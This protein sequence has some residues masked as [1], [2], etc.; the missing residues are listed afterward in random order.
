MTGRREI[1]LALG[2]VSLVGTALYAERA[3]RWRAASAERDRLS[4]RRPAGV[5]VSGFDEKSTADEVTQGLDLSGKTILV[6]GVTSGIGLETMRV[7][8]LRGA[9]V[10]GTGR[11][12]DRAQAACASVGGRT[13]PLMLELTDYPSV[14]ACAERVRAIGAPLDVLVCNAGVM[15]LQ[16][17]EQVDG[18]ERHFATNHLGHFL[19]VCHLMDLVKGAPQG[20]VVVVS[21]NNLKG[22]NPK[23]IE[24][25]NLDGQRSYDPN[26]AYGQSKL[27]NAL[28]SL[29]LSHRLS[30]TRA[31]SNSLH[32]GY[33]DTPLFRRYPLSLRGYR[34]I[35]TSKMN[36]QQGAAT[37]CYV[38]TA[39]ALRS[40]N[41]C[42]FSACN[43]IVPDPR[44]TDLE[45][46][47]RLWFVSEQLLK[48]Y[49]PQR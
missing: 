29:E 46:A 36:V 16:M 9:H 39:P 28:F 17:L 18:I 32:P 24:W 4:F 42:F 49:L 43:P 20:R 22:S 40:V 12:I 3:R 8:A 7:L 25:D 1:L 31:T 10:L 15:G 47:Q 19:L 5:P 34:G 11:T 21:S 30:D 33:V 37:S 44:A 38:A 48:T 35:F 6:T 26:R 14:V 13:T 45:A 23:G 27:A 41:G 2:A